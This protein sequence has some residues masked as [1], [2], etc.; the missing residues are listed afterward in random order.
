MWSRSP[1][2]VRRPVAALGAGPRRSRPVSDA[3]GHRPSRPP[4]FVVDAFQRR[5]ELSE[6]DGSNNTSSTRCH[7]GSL[8]DA[9]ASVHSDPLRGLR[10]RRGH[11]VGT[12]SRWPGRSRRTASCG[13]GRPASP[14]RPR[15]RRVHRGRP[16]Q[17]L[18]MSH[19]DLP[20]PMSRGGV[21]HVPQ[22]PSPT[23]QRTRFTD[24][25]P[26]SLAQ[27]PRTRLRPVIGPDLSGIGLTS[28]MRHR[29]VQRRT[30]PQRPHQH[31]DQLLVAQ[32][33]GSSATSSAT[34]SPNSVTNTS[35]VRSMHQASPGC[36][37]VKPCPL[38]DMLDQCVV[39]GE[40]R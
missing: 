10:R 24:R 1:P 29:R 6:A 18:H 14:R 39:T 38:H 13:R 12:S 15:T 3:D 35:A 22:P 26:R 28:Q 19:R 34:V 20:R 5:S 21:G 4:Q 8:T 7:R 32:P 40:S 9:G 27:P 25:A 17:A 33:V 36:V 11:G 30:G 2:G 23:H 37:T 31:A 16:D